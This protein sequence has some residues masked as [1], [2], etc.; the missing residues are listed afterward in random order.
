MSEFNE[1]LFMREL[2]ELLNKHKLKNCIFAGDN[3]DDKMIGLFCAEK[4]GVG[5]S[6]KN[7]ISAYAH[8]ARL[9]QSAR[10]HMFRTFDKMQ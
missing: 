9:Y 10:E 5:Y 4:Y 2:S 8:S 7:Q 6:F 3:E 1:T